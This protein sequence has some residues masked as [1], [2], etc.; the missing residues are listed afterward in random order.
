MRARREKNLC[1]NCDE[2]YVPGHRCKVR[3]IYMIMSEEEEQAYIEDTGQ[4]EQQVEDVETDD[5]TISINA[6]SGSIGSNTLRVKGKV[7]GKDI[8]IYSLIVGVPT[9][10][11]MRM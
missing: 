7:N 9:V 3:Q 4:T 2:T 8:Y 1:Y 5:I 10:L 11:W 6:M